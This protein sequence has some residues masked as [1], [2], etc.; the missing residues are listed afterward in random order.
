MAAE[1]V[2]KALKHVWVS[3]QPLQVPMAVMGGLALAAWRHVRA[4]RDVD[5]LIGVSNDDAEPLLS[6]LTS[7]GLRP[8]H[9]PPLISLGSLQI[10]QLLYEPPGAFLD[11]Q[12]D[13]LLAQSDYHRQALARRTPTRLA[14][15]DFDLDVLACEDLILHKLL[16]GRLVDR[17][18]AAMLLR[19][20]RADLDLEY[21]VG[22]TATLSLGAELAEVWGEAFPGEAT[23]E[24]GGNRE[25]GAAPASP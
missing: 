17:A 3:L 4:T 18:D 11:L 10:L 21:L 15:L 2:L 6:T 5:L 7:A 9:Q 13:L 20:N 19:A 14:A 12:V 22:W 16:A 8:K 23:P 24:T 25:A 1:V